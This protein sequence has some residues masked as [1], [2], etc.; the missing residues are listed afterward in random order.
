[1]LVVYRSLDAHGTAE[2]AIADAT[3]APVVWFEKKPRI[4]VVMEAVERVAK[5]VR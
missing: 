1:V 5:K 3:D 4:G 2:P